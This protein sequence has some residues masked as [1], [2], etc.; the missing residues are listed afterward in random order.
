MHTLL[1]IPILQ[2]THT[3]LITVGLFTMLFSIIAKLHV[4][5]QSQKTPQNLTE[6]DLGDYIMQLLWMLLL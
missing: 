3:D 4:N 1:T 2:Y 6:S 5:I